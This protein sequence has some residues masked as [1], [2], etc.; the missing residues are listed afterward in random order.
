MNGTVHDTGMEAAQE[1]LTNA[2]G[3][4]AGST[5][6]HVQA[7]GTEPDEGTSWRFA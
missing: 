6:E 3:K 7:N 4:S 2:D 5:R 1:L